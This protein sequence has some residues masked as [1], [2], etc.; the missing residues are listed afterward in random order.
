MYLIYLRVALAGDIFFSFSQQ[1][2]IILLE[3]ALASIDS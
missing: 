3:D 2:P 1:A